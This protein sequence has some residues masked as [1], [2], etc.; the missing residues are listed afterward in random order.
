MEVGPQGATSAGAGHTRSV[1][2]RASAAAD[3]SSVATDLDALVRRVTAAAEGVADDGAEAVAS[4]LYEVERA[5]R[6]ASRR[7]QQTLRALP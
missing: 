7:L 4:D 2:D 5:L 6:S 1:P 3:L